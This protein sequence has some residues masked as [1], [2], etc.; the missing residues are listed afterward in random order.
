MDGGSKSNGDMQLYQLNETIGSND[1]HVEREREEEIEGDGGDVG[2]DTESEEGD[3]DTGLNERLQVLT[4]KY[5]ITQ[6]SH[7]P[8][9]SWDYIVALPKPSFIQSYSVPASAWRTW[10]SRVAATTNLAIVLR[11]ISILHA[12]CSV[13]LIIAG[14]VGVVAKSYMAY[15]AVTIWSP[16]LIFLPT[17]IV[18]LLAYKRLR[19]CSAIR[20]LT[21]LSI[22]SMTVSL[23]LSVLS[24]WFIL[25]DGQLEIDCCPAPAVVI[26]H[27][28]HTEYR[29]FIDALN[30]F[31]LL[32]EL[33]ASISSV[34]VCCIIQPGC[35]MHSRDTE[36][37]LASTSTSYRRLDTDETIE[38]VEDFC[39]LTHISTTNNQASSL[40]R[41]S[42][43]A[44]A[45]VGEG[46][47]FGD[48]Y[49]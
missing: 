29:V 21:I 20:S 39:S 28:R 16:I 32:I 45:L 2:S 9:E 42:A 47:E 1:A 8:S 37:L 30:V 24:A 34:A 23:S 48:F 5:H 19:S 13:L 49:F 46:A 12:L 27:C 4:R 15:F 3:I 22:L 18:G 26:P 11:N 7:S 44:P 33:I 6:P 41:R 31:L 17:S 25:R 10:A 14:V 43:S 38:L 36:K 35:C 40:T